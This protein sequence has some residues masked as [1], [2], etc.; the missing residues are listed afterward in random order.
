MKKKKKRILLIHSLSLFS[1][2]STK[3]LQRKTFFLFFFSNFVVDTFT[4][5]SKMNVLVWNSKEKIILFKVEN[6]KLVRTVLLLT[7]KEKF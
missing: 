2:R 5:L 3:F 7:Q 6:A 4:I 1:A